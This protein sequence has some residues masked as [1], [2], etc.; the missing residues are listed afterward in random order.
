MNFANKKTDIYLT[1][2]KLNSEHI[3]QITSEDN[4]VG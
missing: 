3:D 4:D 1:D 2:I